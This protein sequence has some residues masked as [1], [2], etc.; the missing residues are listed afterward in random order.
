MRLASGGSLCDVCGCNRQERRSVRG[1]YGR[2]ARSVG[3][4]SGICET[5]RTGEMIGTNTENVTGCLKDETEETGASIAAAGLSSATEIN[6]TNQ[7]PLKSHME[8]HS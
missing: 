4:I 8:D 1:R 5:V 2:A 7:G 3:P 6:R